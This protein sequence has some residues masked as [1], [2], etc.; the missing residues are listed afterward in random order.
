MPIRVFIIISQKRELYNH[1]LVHGLAYRRFFYKI[2]PKSSDVYQEPL[3]NMF[4]E[5]QSSQWIFLVKIDLI[6]IVHNASHNSLVWQLAWRGNLSD[7]DILSL[8]TPPDIPANIN[9]P[10]LAIPEL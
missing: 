9:H 6:I 5:S 2:D 8:S 3:R 7:N 10:S 4:S 1:Q